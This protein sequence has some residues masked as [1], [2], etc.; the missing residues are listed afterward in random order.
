MQSMKTLDWRGSL[1]VGALAL[2]GPQRS[3]YIVECEPHY[4]I[5]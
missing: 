4:V 2:T 3:Q 1:G 5:A